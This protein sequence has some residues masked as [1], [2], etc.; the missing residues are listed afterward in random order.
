MLMYKFISLFLFTSILTV[1]GCETS[2]E[3]QTITTNEDDIA[4]YEAMIEADQEATEEDAASED[5]Q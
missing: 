2:S 5:S 1:I 4:R 3:P